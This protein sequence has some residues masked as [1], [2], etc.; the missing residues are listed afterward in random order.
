MLTSGLSHIAAHSVA[1]Y[2]GEEF[3]IL[4]PNASISVA[5]QVA[6][7]VRQRTKGIK[8]RDRRSNHVGISITI[9]GGVAAL[10]AGDDVKSLIERADR[11]LY[12]AKMAGRDRINGY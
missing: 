7:A 8:I 10:R 9:S 5:G 12:Q 1:R 2:G 3:A 4:L 11:A 6:E